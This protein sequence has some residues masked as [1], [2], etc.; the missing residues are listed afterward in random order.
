MKHIAFITDLHVTGI[1]ENAKNVDTRNNFQN[2]LSAI[3]GVNPDLL[4]IGGDLCWKAPKME[5]YEWIK[6]QLDQ[7]KIPYEIIPGNHDDVIM[8]AKCF[9]MT[10]VQNNN[11]S[12]IYY[13]KQIGDHNLVFLD[14][15]KG[16]MSEEQYGFLHMKYKT[17]I[18]R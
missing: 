8:M 3:K 9:G 11:T 12:E 6:P 4:I 17:T 10:D 15:S 13:V 18:I 16:E 2:I 14:T 1:D 5:I 7:L